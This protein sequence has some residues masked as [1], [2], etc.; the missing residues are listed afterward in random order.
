MLQQPPGGPYEHGAALKRPPD[1]KAAL[2]LQHV[3]KFLFKTELINI[4]AHVFRAS[5]HVEL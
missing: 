5:G 4:T 3:V 1:G 2:G